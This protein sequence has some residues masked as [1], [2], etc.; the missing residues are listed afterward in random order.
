MNIQAHENYSYDQPI[1]LCI[2]IIVS[3]TYNIKGIQDKV[4]TVKSH[5]GKN[6]SSVF[7]VTV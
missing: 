6:K 3:C 2:T 1:M 7:R 4:S 5:L